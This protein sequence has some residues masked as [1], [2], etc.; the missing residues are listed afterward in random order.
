MEN[1]FAP[2]TEDEINKTLS[3]YFACGENK[4]QTAKVL[5]I[6]RQSLQKRIKNHLTDQYKKDREIVPADLPE[7]DI[8]TEEI[9]KTMCDRFSARKANADAT[10]WRKFQVN[11]DK[12]IGI[13]WFGDPHLD[14]NGCNWPALKEH[15]EIVA[16][17]EGM[18]GANIGDSHNN[19]VGRLM[20]EYANQ[21]TSIATAY[22]LIEWFF[23]DSG[24]DWLIMLTGN[25]DSWNDDA[26]YLKS[27][28]K[29][30]CPMVDWRAQINLVFKNGREVKID[31]AHDHKG[32][33]QWNALHGQQKASSM[34]GSADLYI[35]GHRHNWA[36]AQNE[37]PETGRVYHLA[38]ARGYKH[39]DQYAVTCG[40][41]NQA[42]GSSIVTIIDPKAS[43]LNLV[44]CFS[45][46]R[47]GAEYLKFLR[48]R[49]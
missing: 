13:C 11:T 23:K 9:I 37:C 40:F 19:W 5:G 29:N 2:L 25:H 47:E 12:P 32:H 46:V 8:P 22:K 6:T 35:A 38:R 41:G 24:I 15:C 43:P 49:K 7:E 36:L 30:I 17:T 33:S 31:A 21:D 45:D 10:K 39:I 28:C 34:G 48:G 14:D 16:E 27:V 4:S 42:H 20:R 18:Y 44:R 3:V 26:R 1:L